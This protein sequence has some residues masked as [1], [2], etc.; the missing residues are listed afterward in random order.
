MN[1]L[2][3][4]TEPQRAHDTNLPTDALPAVGSSALLGRLRGPETIQLPDMAREIG[5]VTE[6]NILENGDYSMKITPKEPV[7]LHG[8]IKLKSVCSV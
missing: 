7:L 4:K 5:S 2:T 6:I 8:N 3:N 1:E